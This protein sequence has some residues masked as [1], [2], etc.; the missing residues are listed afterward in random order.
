ML[1]HTPVTQLVARRAE[2]GQFDRIESE[3]A[4]RNN[5]PLFRCRFVLVALA[6]FGLL[7]L[8]SGVPGAELVVRDVGV[9]PVLVQEPHV[10]FVSKAGVGGND[11]FVRALENVLANFQT[12]QTVFHRFQNQ[13]QGMMLLAFAKGLGIDYDL[14]LPVHG[15]DTVVTLD[16]ALAGVM[17]C[18]DAGNAVFAG[19]KNCLGRLN[20]GNIAFDFFRPFTL[21]R[22]PQGCGKCGFCRSK[23]LPGGRRL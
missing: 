9:D 5:V 4:G 2:T 10:G 8:E 19:A 1:P 11:G 12:V 15:G 22:D 6:V 18:R 16:G 21:P 17:T 7:V 14:M 23:N 20:V 3:F 13:L